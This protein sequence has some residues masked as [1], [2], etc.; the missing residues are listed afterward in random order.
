M[1]RL[2]KINLLGWGKEKKALQ[3]YVSDDMKSLI[4]LKESLK[5]TSQSHNWRKMETAR[6]CEKLGRRNI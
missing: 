5:L 2:R 3:F 4:K 6:T 1:Q